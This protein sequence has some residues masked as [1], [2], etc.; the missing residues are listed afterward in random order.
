[1]TLTQLSYVLAIVDSDLNVTRAAERV[2]ATQSGVSKQIRKLE[3]E[4]GFLIF[5]RKGRKLLSLTPTGAQVAE[6]A[7][8]VVNE[9]RNLRSL[10]ANLRNEDD[11]ELRVATTHTQARYV[12]P[13]AVAHLRRKFPGVGVHLLPGGDGEIRDLLARGDVDVAILSTANA[14]PPP[15]DHAIPL[16]E[17]DRVVVVTHEHPLAFCKAPPDLS[18]L[19]RF[20]L[21]TYESALRPDSSLRRSFERAGLEPHI[22]C[23]ARDADLIKTYV[24][25][26]LGVGILAEMAIVP[27]DA[28]ELRTYAVPDLFPRCTAWLLLRGD[29]LLR[30]YALEFVSQVTARIDLQDLRRGLAADGPQRWSDP[31]GWGEYRTRL[32][33]GSSKI[34]SP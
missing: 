8:T 31:F 26:G 11:G 17:W 15:A 23:T 4:L 24:R 19:A 12:L 6:C 21:V 18:A 29:R 7:R 5:T 33:Q 10:A 13:A 34:I 25:S 28:G 20:P 27:E 9:I 22:A 2:Y 32:T 1:M 30:N 3:D 14:A 16:Y